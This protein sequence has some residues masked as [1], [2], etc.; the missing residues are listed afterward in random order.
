MEILNFESPSEFVNFLLSPNF[1]SN[2]LPGQIEDFLLFGAIICDVVW[3][4]RNHFIFEN[5][6]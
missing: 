5:F 3:K 2:L 4:Q 1:A 6:D